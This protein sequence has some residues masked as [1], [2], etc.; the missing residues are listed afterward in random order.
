MEAIMPTPDVRQPTLARRLRE[1]RQELYGERG[2]PLLAEALHLPARTWRSYE[3]G[4]DIPGR[5]LL[6]FTDISG[7]SL[8]W[9]L[10]GEGE[11]F[12]GGTVPA[13]SKC[14]ARR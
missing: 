5:K 4:A 14:P 6:R 13:A 12:P 9:L 7:A 8:P 1:V 3:A 11:P 2:G 10:T